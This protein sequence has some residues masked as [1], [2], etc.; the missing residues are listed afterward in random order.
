MAPITRLL[1]PTNCQKVSTTLPGL[2]DCK[3]SLVLETFNEIRKIVVN[4][5]IDGK[6]DICKI[7]FANNALNKI[8]M[9]NEMF[10]AKN[11]SRTVEFIGIIKNI[12]AASKY[13]PI[14]KSDFFIL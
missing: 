11:I 13:N 14:A 10:K 6:D 12:I 1:P 9:A 3:I 8:T 2:P 4:N 7:S 5:M